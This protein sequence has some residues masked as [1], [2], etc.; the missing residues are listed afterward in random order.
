MDIETSVFIAR[1]AR[2]LPP[3][4][5]RSGPALQLFGLVLF[6]GT[7]IL[8]PE[9]TPNGL[10]HEWFITSDV[11]SQLILGYFLVYPLVMLHEFCHFLV[12][13][14]A[15]LRPSFN[16]HGPMSFSVSTPGQLVTRHQNLL[17][18]H[19]P[20]LP[21]NLAGLLGMLAFERFRPAIAIALAIHLGGCVGDFVMINIFHTLPATTRS[22]DSDTGMYFSEEAAG[23]PV[24]QEL[25][26]CD[27][28]ARAAH[29]V[30]T[31]S[32]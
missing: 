7:A 16:K 11:F 12:L 6:G 28:E 30:D 17:C 22:R 18:L 9:H 3:W 1:P 5:T 4:M 14:T 2:G 8:L 23:H 10:F 29:K 21:V 32:A 13:R 19:A 24:L 27:K 31:S 20:T 15:G 25:I 26:E